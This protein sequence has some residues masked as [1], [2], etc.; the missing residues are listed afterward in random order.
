MAVAVGR[1]PSKISRINRQLLKVRTDFERMAA[2]AAQNGDHQLERMCQSI[3]RRIDT[4][5]PRRLRSGHGSTRP[6]S[7]A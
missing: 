3:V 6:K 5:L 2:T 7:R 1:A 4:L